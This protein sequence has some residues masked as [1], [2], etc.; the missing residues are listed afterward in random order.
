M[1][2]GQEIK[3]IIE[4]QGDSFQSDSKIESDLVIACK[5]QERGVKAIPAQGLK[6]CH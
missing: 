1:A 4:K 2:S 6:R 3:V 5:S